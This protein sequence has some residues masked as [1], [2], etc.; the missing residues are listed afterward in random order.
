[1]NTTYRDGWHDMHLHARLAGDPRPALAGMMP[2][3]R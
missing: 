2:G 3:G 1:M